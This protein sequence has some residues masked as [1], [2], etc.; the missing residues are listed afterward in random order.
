MARTSQDWNSSY[1]VD[2]S[3]QQYTLPPEEAPKKFK[4]KHMQKQKTEESKEFFGGGFF[5]FLVAY[6]LCNGS[7]VFGKEGRTNICHLKKK[8]QKQ[9]N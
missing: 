2:F 6:S 5:F 1:P 9:T 7:A 3:F 4:N 8:Q